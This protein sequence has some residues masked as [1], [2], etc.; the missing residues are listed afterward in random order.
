ML[1]HPDARLS[2]VVARKVVGDQEDVAGRIV[3]FDIRKQSNIVGRV[4]RSGTPGQLLAI[5]HA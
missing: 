1:G 4:A 2:A 5:V 3:G